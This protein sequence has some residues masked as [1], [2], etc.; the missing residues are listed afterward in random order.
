M[1]ALQ[2]LQP[3]GALLQV[4]ATAQ[5]DIEIVVAGERVTGVI[6]TTG[7]A[8]L[9]GDNRSAQVGAPQLEDVLRPFKLLHSCRMRQLAIGGQLMGQCGVLCS[10]VYCAVWCAV[11]LLY[12]GLVRQLKS[13]AMVWCGVV[14]YIQIVAVLN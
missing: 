3:Y 9:W 5:L 7:T 8:Y 10:V 12:F 2:A 11:L 13:S 1:L 6:S 14:C 4:K